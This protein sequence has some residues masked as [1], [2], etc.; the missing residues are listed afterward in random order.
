MKEKIRQLEALEKEINTLEAGHININ[1]HP[2]SD[3]HKE[4]KSMDN[5]RKM[6]KGAMFF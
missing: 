3:L 5:E 4:I 6:F 2:D 1:V